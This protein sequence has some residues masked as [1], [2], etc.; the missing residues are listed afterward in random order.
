[1]LSRWL[2]RSNRLD[3]VDASQ[4]KE[5]LERLSDE[6]IVELQS[7]IC[8]MV[9][10]DPDADVQ[11]AAIKLCTDQNRLTALLEDKQLSQYA[12]VRIAHLLHTNP[13]NSTDINQAHIH[14]KVLNAYLKSANEQQAQTMLRTV[15]DPQLL[16]SIALKQAKSLRNFVLTLP[17]LNTESGLNQLEKFSRGKDKS[18]NRHARDKLELI[19]QA[20]GDV[21]Q[22]QARIAEIDA[23]INKELKQSPQDADAVI[24]HRTKL[25]KLGDSR[26]E[27]L[28]CYH[29]ANLALGN[30]L[31]QH[32]VKAIAESPLASVDLY[33]PDPNNNPYTGL[34]KELQNLK[35]KIGLGTPFEQIQILRDNL[36]E[37]WLSEADHFPPNKQQQTIFEE[38]SHLFNQ[39]SQAWERYNKQNWQQAAQELN[40]DSQWQKTWRKHLQELKWPK[41]IQ[42]PQAIRT[43]QAALQLAETHT[44]TEKAQVLDI[45]KKLDECTRQAQNY[46]EDGATKQA[47]IALKQAR[48]LMEQLADA[49]V[50]VNYAQKQQAEKQIAKLSAQL[51]ELRD[52]QKFATSPKRAALVEEVKELADNPK[53]P[54]TQQAR[55]RHLRNEWQQLGPINSAKDHQLA[56]AFDDHAEKAFEPCKSYFAEQSNIRAQNLNGRKEIVGQ[57]TQ[58]LNATDWNNVDLKAAETIMRTARTSWRELHPCDRKALK[59]VEEQFEALQKQLHERVKQGWDKNVEIKRQLLEQAKEL[60]ALEVQN[61]VEQAKQLQKQW[62]EVGPTPRGVD[63]RLWREFRRVCDQIFT[64]LTSQRE[65]Q[66]AEQNAKYEAIQ[67]EIEKLESL[68]ETSEID[69]AAVRDQL[70]HIEELRIDTKISKVLQQRIAATQDKLD[71]HR[72]Q[73]AQQKVR[74]QI[75]QWQVWDEEISQAEIS[76]AELPN[77]APHNYFTQRLQ[78]NACEDNLLELTLLA[79]IAADQPSPAEDQAARMS[80]QV[81]LMN[82]GR[83]SFSEQDKQ[84][85]IKRWCEAGP[86]DASADQ[87]R[88]R[89]FDALTTTL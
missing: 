70:A 19:K 68:V 16:A 15:E 23:A 78:G 89:F 25:A 37:K 47:A 63:Q 59:P 14:P 27:L 12:A 5:A 56:Q 66:H 3:H 49:A 33:I 10:S 53:E 74:D 84:A 79:E 58:Y 32:T 87:L 52:W 35:E 50:K 61:Q 30:L 62:R 40:T 17:A 73:T 76:G 67:K 22:N 20:R 51:A 83:R 28:E 36:A 43:L 11:I 80:L 64:N 45:Q 42:A 77:Q 48:G 57:L 86:K 75:G 72:K 81:D 4:R 39:Y 34:A 85:L 54:P 8:K 24:V 6:Q 26:K 41:H 38:V 55:L 2:R 31:P 88:K 21:E 46:V 65:A 7:D 82:Q 60:D 44:Q 9:E 18:C 1:M 29:Q 71:L 13:T 69:Q